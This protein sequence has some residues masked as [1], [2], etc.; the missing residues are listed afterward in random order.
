MVIQINTKKQGIPVNI[1]E[2]EFFVGT[3]DVDLEK[4]E[5]L[6]KELKEEFEKVKE[7]TTLGELRKVLERGYDG[8]LGEGAFTKVYN[9]TPSTIE[10]A[11]YLA[12]LYE[13]VLEELQELS[14]ANTQQGKAEKYLKKKN[15]K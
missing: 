4:F 13:G 14:F 11:K 12:Q 3:S 7:V 1:G 9:Q 8:L 10:C 2:L 6:Q 5:G 15:K